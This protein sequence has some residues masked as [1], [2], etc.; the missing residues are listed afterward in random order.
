LAG[1]KSRVFK[2]ATHPTDRPPVGENPFNKFKNHP[3][4][5]KPQK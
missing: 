3:P 5:D 2:G 1:V 4:L